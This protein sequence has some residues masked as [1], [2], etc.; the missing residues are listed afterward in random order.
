MREASIGRTVTD[1]ESCAF[2]V[3]SPANE[4]TTAALILNMKKKKLQNPFEDAKL[5]PMMIDFLYY[6]RDVQDIDKNRDL[7]R[8]Y[9]EVINKV[10]VALGKYN[11]N[12]VSTNNINAYNVGAL[13]E[14]HYLIPQRKSIAINVLRLIRNAIAHCSISV[15]EEQ[16]LCISNHY[17]KRLTAYAKI[18]LSTF[19]KLLKVFN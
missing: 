9:P 1:T 15:D 18:S 17:H 5:K 8:I 7:L 6:Y 3:N 2:F 19:T 4:G 14:N 12:R 11:Y 10:F 16:L 13:G